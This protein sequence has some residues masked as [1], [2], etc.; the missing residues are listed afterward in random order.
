MSDQKKGQSKKQEQ[1]PRRTRQEIIDY[2]MQEAARFDTQVMPRPQ[3]EIA[4]CLYNLVPKFDRCM[5]EVMNKTGMIGGISRDVSDE[6]ISEANAILLQLDDLA[7]KTSKHTRA[8]Y[9]SP[10]GFG[11]MRAMLKEIE[12]NEKKAV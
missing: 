4:N 1:R 12:E 5:S 6:L 10:H 8:F 3:T 7:K 11:A 2:K 9:K